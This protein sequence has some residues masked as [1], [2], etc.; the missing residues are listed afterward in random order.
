MRHA[1][2]EVVV[3][4]GGRL[5]G[6]GNDFAIGVLVVLFHA[7]N[8]AASAVVIASDEDDDRS[9]N[10][11]ATTTTTTT[12]CD[13]EATRWRCDDDGEGGERGGDTDI[14]RNFALIDGFLRVFAVVVDC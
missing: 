7:T 4:P 5:G 14:V 2:V 3:R 1:A 13:V 6:R 10:A 11:D 9:R 8:D 12:R